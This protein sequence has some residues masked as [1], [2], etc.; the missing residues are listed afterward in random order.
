MSKILILGDKKISSKDI[1]NSISFY[2]TKVMEI[3]KILQNIAKSYRRN[4]KP[5]TE[6]ILLAETGIVTS[7]TEP[8]PAHTS[9]M[10]C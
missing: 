5:V 7:V 2:F 9:L 8:Y 3:T 10:K 1:L 6:S 4:H